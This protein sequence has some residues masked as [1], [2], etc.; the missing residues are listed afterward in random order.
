MSTTENEDLFGVA[1][2]LRC[3]EITYRQLDYWA[4][5][6]WIAGGT[7]GHGNPRAWTRRQILQVAYQARLV[8]AGMLP[9]VAALAITTLAEDRPVTLA[10]GLIT[11][12]PTLEVR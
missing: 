12:H 7:P 3:T 6:G 4:A 8:R 9:G 10:D 11:L 5:Q 2:L 1:D